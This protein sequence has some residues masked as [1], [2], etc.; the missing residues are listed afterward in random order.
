MTSCLLS[1]SDCAAIKPES[2]APTT[3]TRIREL[4]LLHDRAEQKPFRHDEEI[5]EARD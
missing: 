3:M 2:P 4:P 1:E 5:Q